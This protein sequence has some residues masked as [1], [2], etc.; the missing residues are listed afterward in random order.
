M[1]NLQFDVAHDADLSV[2][3][4]EIGQG[5]AGVESVLAAA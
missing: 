1:A 5:Q 4:L 2:A 3:F